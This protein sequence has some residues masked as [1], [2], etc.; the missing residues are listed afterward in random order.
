MAP[1]DPAA[2]PPPPPPPAPPPPPPAIPPL[3]PAGPSGDDH[4]IALV[5]DLSIFVVPVIGGLVVYLI[6]GTTRPWLRQQGA[7]M[8]NFQITLFIAA[9]I[10]A[11]LIFVLIGIPLFLAVIVIGIVFPIIAAVNHGQQRSY[12]YPLAIPFVSA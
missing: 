10:S 8:L 12:R 2:P 3:S 5:G 1:D 11:L 4:V 7:W 9:V 6:A